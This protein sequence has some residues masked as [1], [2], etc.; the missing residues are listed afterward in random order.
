ML[1]VEDLSYNIGQHN[2]LQDISLECKKGEL[3]AILGANGA[4]KSTLL[5]AI[6]KKI[7]AHKGAVKWDDTRLEHFKNEEMARWRGV[8]TQSSNVASQFLVEEV[9]MMGRYP[10]F[11]NNPSLKDQAEVQACLKLVKA[12]DKSD[13]VFNSLSGGEK[14]RVHLARVLAQMSFHTDTHANKLLL[15]DEPLNNLDISHQHLCL[16]IARDFA[17]RGNAVL[18]VIHDINLAI[19]YAHQLVFLKNGKLLSAGNA[20]DT[21]TPETIST[22]YDIDAQIAEFDGIKKVF[23]GTKH[24]TKTDKV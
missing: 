7:K 11:K 9:A 20:D 10:F 22:C 4:G 14:Q 13:R 24:L 15:L 16:Q 8:L 6:A 17:K 23:F 12:D 2:I 18:M 1:L 19:E 21:C 3:T 5:N